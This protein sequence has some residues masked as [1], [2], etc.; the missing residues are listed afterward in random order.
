MEWGLYFTILL[1]ALGFGLIAAIIVVFL[2]TALNAVRLPA[3]P[4]E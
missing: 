1:Q 3:P 2:G 4:K